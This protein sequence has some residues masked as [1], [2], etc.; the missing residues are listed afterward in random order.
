MSQ[1]WNAIPARYSAIVSAVA[2]VGEPQVHIDAWMLRAVNQY[3][4]AMI[5]AGAPLHWAGEL[6]TN[7]LEA[8]FLDTADHDVR[9][10]MALE[11]AYGHL[12]VCIFLRNTSPPQPGSAVV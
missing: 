12:V 4:D 6:L 2:R 10:K 7:E 1:K 5:Q 9:Y 11:L 8:A 3:L